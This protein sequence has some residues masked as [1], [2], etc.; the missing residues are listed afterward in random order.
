MED[1]L[2]VHM[3]ALLAMKFLMVAL[4]NVFMMTMSHVLS[5]LSLLQ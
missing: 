5:A 2:L 3:V 4:S 1:L